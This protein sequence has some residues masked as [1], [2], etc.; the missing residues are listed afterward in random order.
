MKT[1]LILHDGEYYINLPAEFI[2]QLDWYENDIVN[3]DLDLA[4]SKIEIF[5]K[6]D[7]TEELDAESDEDF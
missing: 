2:E 1:Q 4:F 7:E 6:G 3:I 5:K